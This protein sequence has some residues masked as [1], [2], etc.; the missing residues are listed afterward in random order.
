MSPPALFLR[1]VPSTV[2]ARLVRGRRL[3]SSLEDTNCTRGKTYRNS[4]LGDLV[5]TAQCATPSPHSEACCHNYHLCYI[6]LPM[7]DQCLLIK[8]EWATWVAQ[9]VSW[10]S[11][12]LVLAQVMFS[13]FREP[14]DGLCVDSKESAWD[15]L[16]PSLSAPLP[17]PTLCAQVHVCARSLSKQINKL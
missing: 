6:D 2:A 5:E 3:E 11:Q 8:N 9:S 13:W 14:R 1:P 17:S 7:A 16:S 4:H 10:A 12:L 15:S